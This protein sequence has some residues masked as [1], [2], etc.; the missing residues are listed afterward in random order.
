[1]TG[2]GLGLDLS[3]NRNKPLDRL[4][5]FDKVDVEVTDSTA[6]PFQVSRLT[7]E[8][9][10]S[11]DPYAM[12]FNA[13][14]TG[15]ELATFAGGQLAGPLGSFL[16]GMASGALP[17]TNTPIPVTVD[18]TMKSDGGRPTVQSVNGT[19]AGLPAGPLLGALIQ[20]V[21]PSF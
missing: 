12:S 5:G 19:I 13:T 7:L 14:V 1:M 3:V 4:D 17:N 9:N 18:A 8:R 11:G 21:G 2:S 6:G 15:S 20:A 10:G 16:G